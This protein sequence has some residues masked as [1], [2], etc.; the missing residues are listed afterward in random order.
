MQRRVGELGQHAAAAQTPVESDGDDQPVGVARHEQHRA[1]QQDAVAIARRP[2]GHRDLGHRAVGHADAEQLAGVGLDGDQLAAAG[3]EPDAVQVEAGLVDHGG[4]GEVEEP[5]R[6]GH[7]GIAVAHR[8]GGHAPRHR[9]DRVGE[10][11][12]AVG[13]DGDV[14]DERV[15]AA[16]PGVEVAHQLAVVGV[17]DPHLAGG[18]AGD[19]EP[20]LPV[21]LH[22]GGGGAALRPTGQ[23]H[24]HGAA[25]GT[26]AVDGAVGAAAHV[27]EPGPRVRG[28]ALGEHGVA[29]DGEV[30]DRPGRVP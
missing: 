2:A 6:R 5:P 21:D 27:E 14:V 12:V 16:Q 23:E 10:V 15:G 19:V 24:L 18:G 29:G 9:R 22:P 26:A 1:G 8:G 7:G 17:V 28:D 11:G 4:A 13:G 3:R 25:V 30:H 20:A